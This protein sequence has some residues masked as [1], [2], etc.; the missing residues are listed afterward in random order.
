MR[1]KSSFLSRL[2]LT[3]MIAVT[4]ALCNPVISRAA[5]QYGQ[6]IDLDEMTPEEIE[7]Y[8]LTKKYLDMNKTNNVSVPF[9]KKLNDKDS[10]SKGRGTNSGRGSVIP[11]KYDSRTDRN[12]HKNVISSVK[13]QSSTGL[14]W[15]FAST[16]AVQASYLSKNDADSIDLSEWK[17]GYFMYHQTVDPLGIT[18]SDKVGINSSLGSYDYYQNGGNPWLSMFG[19]SKGIGFVNEDKADFRKLIPKV[20]KYENAC[21]NDNMCYQNDYVLKDTY[22]FEAGDESQRKSIKKYIMELGAGTIMYSSGNW[23]DYDNYAYYNPYYKSWF[24]GHV[25]A[26]V[27]W[28]DDYPKENFVIPPE[29]D[30]AWLIKNS[31]GTTW[32]NDGYFWMSYDEESSYQNPV[33]FF[34]VEASGNYDNIYQHDG[35]LSDAALDDNHLYEA[36]VFTAEYDETLEEVSFWTLEDNVDYEVS[37]YVNPDT[38]DMMAGSNLA[39]DTS[40]VVAGSGYHKISLANTVSLHK[41]DRFAVV[42]KHSHSGEPTYSLIDSDINYD[43]LTCDSKASAGQSFISDDAN[44]WTDISV[45]GETN[46]RIKA[47]T[48]ISDLS[49]AGALSFGSQN[50]EQSIIE[51]SIQLDVKLGNEIVNDKAPLD[52]T[53]EDTSIINIDRLGRVYPKQIGNTKVTVNYKGMSAETTVAVKGNGVYSAFIIKADDYATNEKPLQVY[54]G[55][56]INLSYN[57]APENLNNKVKYDIEYL[58]GS[59]SDSDSDSYDVTDNV[60][61]LYNSGKY[62][63]KAYVKD[64]EDVLSDYVSFYVNV[65]VNGVDCGSDYTQLKYLDYDDMTVKAFMFHDENYEGDYYFKF[66]ENTELEDDYDY[67][68]IYGSDEPLTLEKVLRKHSGG[69]DSSINRIGKY[70]GKELA[71]QSVEVDYKYAGFVL[72]SDEHENAYGFM[73]DSVSKY[74]ELDTTS[75]DIKDLNCEVK[76]GDTYKLNVTKNPSDSSDDPL[77][78]DYDENIISIDKDGNITPKKIGKTKA[79]IQVKENISDYSTENIFTEYDCYEQDGVWYIFDDEEDE[80]KALT[81]VWGNRYPITITVTGDYFPDS[82]SFKAGSDIE[83]IRNSETKLE[84]NESGIDDFVVGYSSLNPAVAYISDDGILH[85]VASGNTTVTATIE[86]GANVIR[87]SLNVSVKAPDVMTVADMQSVHDYVLGMDE[88]YTYTSQGAECMNI[89]FDNSLAFNG[90]YLETRTKFRRDD[91]I[92]IRDDQGYYYGFKYGKIMRMK[93][94][95]EDSLPDEYLIGDGDIPAF[96]IYSDTVIIHMVS[97]L[98]DSSD[99]DDDDDDDYDDD[100]YDSK[101]NLSNCYGF[102]VKR[103]VAGKKATALNAENMNLSFESYDL[104]SGKL[105]VTRV[106]ADAIDILTY[107]SDD[108]DIA[109]INNK[110]IVYANYEGETT[111]WTETLS[112]LSV[113]ATVKIKETEVTGAKVLARGKNDEY[114]SDIEMDKDSHSSYRFVLEPSDSR[115]QVVALSADS[116]VVTASAYNEMGDY[117]LDLYGVDAGETDVRIVTKKDM[118]KVLCTVH[119]VVKGDNNSENGNEGSDD[120]PSTVPTPGPG[121]PVP[122]EQTPVNPSVQDPV[123]PVQ[124]TPAQ[125]SDPGLEIGSVITDSKKTVNYK[126]LSGDTVAYNS[127]VKKN[128]KSYTVPATVKLSGKNYKVTEVSPNAF[129]GCKNMT[130][131]TIGKNVISIGAKAFYGCKK[132][133]RIN[134]KST[135]LRKVGKNAIRNINKKACIKCN[136]KK[137]KAYKKLF[138][139]KTGFVKTMKFK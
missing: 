109:S 10:E 116:D 9:P 107:S 52:F 15:S 129:K 111:V 88:T 119:I 87:A 117:W 95:S 84:F 33:C 114:V 57:L 124:P 5:D 133:N 125:S 4:A 13:D 80:P 127:P 108:E 50:Y 106:P 37:V 79:Y 72:Q 40:G 20:R 47:F 134:I 94:G 7:G 26:I 91:Y 64:S 49:Y 23:Y 46:L 51:P 39:G 41:G 29:H 105:K 97:K 27:G 96:T 100:D 31:W 110:G 28:D 99:D 1:K 22:L 86:S 101:N 61:K 17:T 137:K 58:N 132:L 11:R 122:G 93:A 85:A 21:M 18:A 126:V 76:L 38:N 120:E 67:L 56:K 131:V 34:E 35:T 44:N 70:T 113:S 118:N 63:I 130:S 8:E 66:N 102:R 103:I 115:V 112:G 83:V 104:E 90:D 53:V 71:G 24:S 45:D 30:G 6:D 139:K 75:I 128:A 92:T 55:Q 98:P 138:S 59:D 78:M 69:Y 16:E 42:I 121:V 82:L 62:C 136:K 19:F 12:D 65:S 48:V 3:G 68:Y 89:F 74:V 36:N 60:I 81:K 32:G 43:W 25:V 123:T 77:F 54:L 135:S 2:L 73:V 14:C